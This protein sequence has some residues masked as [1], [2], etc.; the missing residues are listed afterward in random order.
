M[1]IETA[2]NVGPA[3]LDI[4]YERLGDRSAPPVLLIMGLGAQLI[5]WPD[6]FC[7]ELVRRGLHVIRFDN[8]DVGQSTHLP[9]APLPNMAASLAGDHSSASYTLSDMAGDAAGLLD[10]LGLDSVHVVGA[11]MGGFI[12]QTLAIEHPR[13]VRSLTSIMSST[14]DRAVGQPHPQVM[15]LFASASPTNREEA[16]QRT[17]DAQRVLGSPGFAPDVEAIRDRAGRAY[18]RGFDPLGMARQAV[19]VLASGDRTSRLRSLDV[20]A[21][22]IHGAADPMCDVS[23]GRAT[24]WATTYRRRCGRSS[25]RRSRRTCSAARRGAGADAH[26]TAGRTRTSAVSSTRSIS[27]SM[28]WNASSPMTR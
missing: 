27:S 4:A 15:A 22:V 26:G 2:S 6:G 18:D 12:A 24:A 23:G 9:R 8:R 10:V 14:G 13:R 16:M 5:G 19:A 28:T 11:S 21:L 17:L 1:T 3:R 20:P 25:P 7:D